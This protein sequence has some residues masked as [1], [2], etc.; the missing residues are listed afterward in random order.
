MSFYIEKA[1]FVNRAPFDKI[2]LDF[3]ES[4]INVLSAINGRGK[5]TVLS[6]ITDA[7]YELAKQAFH[8]EFE[9]KEKKYYRISTSLY[10]I[11]A[12]KPSFVYL[13]FRF[14]EKVVDYID[15]RN[16]CSE[17]QYN[18][19]ISLEGKIPYANIG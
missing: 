9:G 3:K 1:I 8:G 2:E 11:D 13:R 17:E 16:Q 5:T 15:V 10:N 14:N 12:S 4:G 7:F 6:H 19:V 18:G